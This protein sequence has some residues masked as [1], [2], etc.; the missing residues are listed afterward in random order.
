MKYGGEIYLRGRMKDE[1]AHHFQDDRD[2]GAVVRKDAT[3]LQETD[4]VR[5]H[6]PDS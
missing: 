6:T 2:L 5:R 3:V 1:D 4:M